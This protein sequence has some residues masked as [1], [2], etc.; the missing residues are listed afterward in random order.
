[1]F[2]TCWVKRSNI[3]AWFVIYWML[4]IPIKPTSASPR[5]LV[6]SSFRLLSFVD[7][8]V[9]IGYATHTKP[10]SFAG[11]E[12]D[13]SFNLNNSK[14][15]DWFGQ[16][17]AKNMTLFED[18]KYDMKELEA[19]IRGLHWGHGRLLSKCSKFVERFVLAV[20]T[21]S[22]KDSFVIAPV[23]PKQCGSLEMPSY[24][25]T[26]INWSLSTTT[27]SSPQL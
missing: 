16:S 17:L 13:R 5:Y 12:K 4:F 11:C 3:L 24:D 19:F 21:G 8:Y 10:P 15:T 27:Q 6:H 7:T 23:Q 2:S 26:S 9:F 1:M 25:P 22:C 18:T 14:C 20:F